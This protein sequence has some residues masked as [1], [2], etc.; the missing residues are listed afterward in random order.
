MAASQTLRCWHEVAKLFWHVQSAQGSFSPGRS[1]DWVASVCSW[2]Y[3]WCR[4]RGLVI[5]VCVWGWKRSSSRPACRKPAT[6]QRP[7]YVSEGT[8][9][10]AR[11]TRGRS[12]RK[13]RWCGCWWSVVGYAGL[14]VEGRGGL[15]DRSGRG[16][17][18]NA[19][20][21]GGVTRGGMRGWVVVRVTVGGVGGAWRAARSLAAAMRRRSRGSNTPAPSSAQVLET[22]A[23]ATSCSRCNRASNKCLP[24][25]RGGRSPFL[26]GVRAPQSTVAVIASQSASRGQLIASSR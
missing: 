14:G 12:M 17:G 23:S 25:G 20:T 15:I 1:G 9:G 4:G 16:R 5:P 2:Q 13:R 7:V 10:V 3:V 8:G 26:S 21:E 11:R 18:V 19:G 6:N 24:S 22:M